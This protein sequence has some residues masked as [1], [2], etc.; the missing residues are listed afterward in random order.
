[1]GKRLDRVSNCFELNHEVITMNLYDY[2]AGMNPDHHIK[3][4]NIVTLM[5]ITEVCHLSV[6]R[7]AELIFRRNFN[8]TLV[9]DP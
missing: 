9:T 8:A 3:S 4:G 7:H 1:M 2:R 6:I 5:I